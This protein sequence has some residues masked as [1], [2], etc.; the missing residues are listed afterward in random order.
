M[1]VPSSILG[2]DGIADIMRAKRQ[3]APP[4]NKQ[5]QQQIPASSAGTGRPDTPPALR[6]PEKPGTEM[7]AAK[8]QPDQELSRSIEECRRAAAD[9][10]QELARVATRFVTRLYEDTLLTTG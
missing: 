3:G 5:T 1:A 2:R 9:L 6:T 8:R 4:L 10:T 7:T